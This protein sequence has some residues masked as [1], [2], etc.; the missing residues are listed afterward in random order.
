MRPNKKMMAHARKHRDNWIKGGL[1]TVLFGL[2]L[3][4]VTPKMLD[5]S[6][7]RLC[8]LKEE[9]DKVPALERQVYDFSNAL[10]RAELRVD[11]QW[12]VCASNREDIAEL[13]LQV[14]KLKVRR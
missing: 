4:W 5:A 10:E 8:A 9:A 2:F 12:S 13:K 1:L 7:G 14:A 11:R 3:T 6:W